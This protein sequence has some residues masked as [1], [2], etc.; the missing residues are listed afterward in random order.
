MWIKDR[1]GMDF[2][3][4][5]NCV[6]CYNIIYNSVPYSLHLQKK[7]TAGIGADALRY[8]FTTETAQECRQILENRDFPFDKHT[9]GHLKRG[10]E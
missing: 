10:V 2:P 3:V 8:D 5:T 1:Y 7:E 6:H 4:E 9:T